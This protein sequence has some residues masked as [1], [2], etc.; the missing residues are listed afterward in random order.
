MTN[1][2]DHGEQAEEVPHVQLS[3]GWIKGDLVTVDK[4]KW[5]KRQ[6]DGKK[7][8][9]PKPSSP[10]ASASG[11]PPTGKDLSAQSVKLEVYG[12]IPFAQPPIG[13]LRFKKP[14][15]CEGWTYIL[16]CTKEREDRR[17][18]PIQKVRLGAN[19]E[20]SED[21]LHLNVWAPQDNT[22]KPRNGWPVLVYAYGG[23]FTAG[24]AHDAKNDGRHFAAEGVVYVTFNYR[25]GP[26][27]FLFPEGG[28]SCCAMWDATA[29]LQWVR[30]EI[31][32]FGGDTDRVTIWGQSAGAD[33][34]LFLMCSDKSKHLFQQAVLMSIS[35]LPIN[36]EQSREVA[37]EF[38]SKCFSAGGGQYQPTLQSM[39]EVNAKQFLKASLRVFSLHP[40]TGP[41]WRLG[42]AEEPGFFPENNF[43]PAGLFS[44]PTEV[45]IDQWPL[46]T[47]IVEKDNE[48]AFLSKGPMDL[49][50]EGIAKDKR[51]IIG[52]C[53]MENQRS[54]TRGSA[55]APK[56]EGGREEVWRRMVWELMGNN[57]GVK[58]HD[59]EAVCDRLLCVY[60]S[61]MIRFRD[62]WTWQ[63][64][65][66]YLSTDFSFLAATECAS[67]RLQ[68]HN[69]K[70]TF[71][72]EYCG[73]DGKR[74]QHGADVN[75]LLEHPVKEGRPAPSQL[76]HVVYDFA[77]GLISFVKTGTPSLGKSAVEWE[78]HTLQ[79]R[80]TMHDAPVLKIDLGKGFWNEP[81]KRTSL[82]TCADLFEDLFSM[83][84]MRD[85]IRCQAVMPGLFRRDHQHKD[86]E[87]TK[88]IENDFHHD[89][90][91]IDAESGSGIVAEASATS[92]GRHRRRRNRGRRQWKE[93]ETAAE[94][95]NN[96]HEKYYGNRSQNYGTSSARRNGYDYNTTDSAHY[97]S[98]QKGDWGN[99]D[100]SHVS[101]QSPDSR[102][103]SNAAHFNYEQHPGTQSRRWSADAISHGQR[104]N[105][106]SNGGRWFPKSSSASPDAKK[107]F[108]SSSQPGTK[109][110]E[111]G[112]RYDG[113]RLS[114][115]GSYES[116]GN[117]PH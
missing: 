111:D 92:S 25:V 89:Y 98:Q 69:P 45:E 55:Y 13:K 78:P 15:P 49:L 103:Q 82:M 112:G 91:A 117:A 61:E 86:E 11:S 32:K 79:T 3:T 4:P 34:A 96:S 77:D 24:S 53:Q 114:Y 51:V 2:R 71:R 27:G 68:Y 9:I 104:N 87:S 67:R 64:M 74:C 94:K 17:W 108:S 106:S 80:Y 26:L 41:G 97:Q 35:S 38:S 76:N 48:E 20:I 8:T 36:V 29:S 50:L 44:M 30:N 107:C 40:A 43:S 54:E 100:T 6:F 23:G 93:E 22:N 109:T 72:Y 116:Y 14:V 1:H 19:R 21:C 75:L 115:L 63:E 31:G 88:T 66:D 62:D 10:N 105:G 5:A 52:H 42:N 60:E 101:R 113:T 56:I 28:D 73:F 39:Q 83:R 110:K 58:R 12:G 95:E 16:D 90:S 102:E 57:A 47:V 99:G 81:L 46:P 37:D 59:L 85:L 33:L 7:V 84:P 65:W 70:G 18:S